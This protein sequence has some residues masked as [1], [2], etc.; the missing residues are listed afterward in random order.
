MTGRRISHHRPSRCPVQ[1]PAQCP[2]TRAPA[3][4][5]LV[6]KYACRG[7][8]QVALHSNYR[9]P[10]YFLIYFCFR[11]IINGFWLPFHPRT[12]EDVF[13]KN[14]RFDVFRKDRYPWSFRPFIVLRRSLT[15]L[16]PEC[17]TYGKFSWPSN[18]T[19]EWAG[20]YIYCNGWDLAGSADPERC[21]NYP[22]HL[23]SR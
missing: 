4:I 22:V 9:S 10:K 15:S 12:I 1:C 20:D 16:E 3:R 13:F 14:A 17:R 6:Q 11:C 7:I 5:V 18:G 8:Y 21:R 23:P 19:E 2:V